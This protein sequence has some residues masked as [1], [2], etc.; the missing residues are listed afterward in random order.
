MP[1]MPRLK[2]RIR[3]IADGRSALTCTR[4]DGTTTWQSLNAIQ[5][6]FFP[7]HDLTHYAV[8]TTLGHR[9]GFYGLVAEGWNLTDFGAPWPRGR[10]PSEALLSETIV[11]LLDLERAT[12][13]R[14]SAADVNARLAEVCAENNIQARE[15]ADAQLD[16]IR[17]KRAELFA[18]WDAVEPGHALELSFDLR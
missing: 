4:S 9:R 10:I 5:G 15:I 8:E 16:G 11:G 18:E 2:I 13:E 12:G 14:V 1:D 3:K 6:R 7:R 17:R